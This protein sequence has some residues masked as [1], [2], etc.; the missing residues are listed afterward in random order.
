M[1]TSSRFRKPCEYDGIDGEPI[2]LLVLIDH[3][4]SVKERVPR[5]DVGRKGHS[6]CDVCIFDVASRGF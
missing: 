3:E 2:A 1:I 5:Y 6:S 4:P